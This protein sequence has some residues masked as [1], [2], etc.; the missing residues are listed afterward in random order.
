[1]RVFVQDKAVDDVVACVLLAVRVYAAARDNGYIFAFAHIK[2]IVYQIVPRAAGHSGRD[3]H[4]LD[5]GFG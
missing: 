2:V 3:I 1:M 5:L 4:G